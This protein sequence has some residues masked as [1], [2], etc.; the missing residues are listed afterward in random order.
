MNSLFDVKY[1]YIYPVML[2][3]KDHSKHYQYYFAFTFA[4]WLNVIYC[5]TNEK[6]LHHTRFRQQ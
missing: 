6:N 4:V 5:K 3:L 1:I 2:T